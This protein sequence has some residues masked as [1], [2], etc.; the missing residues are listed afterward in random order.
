M[1][2]IIVG[3]DDTDPSKRALDRAVEFAKAF[4]AKL[5]VTSVAPVTTPAGGR[6]IGGDPADT[7]L[8][9]RAELATARDHLGA[10]GIEAEY[11]EAVGHAADSIV[12]A[13]ADRGADM[14]IV[15]ARELGFLQRMFSA[16]VS[17]GVAHHARCDVLIVH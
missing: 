11:I 13:A 15:G 1:N 5:V 12:A 17:D 6:S 3:Y 8:D 9:H 16:S 7:P 2:T 14:I 10:A 4:G